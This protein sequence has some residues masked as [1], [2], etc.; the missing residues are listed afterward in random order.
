MLA[1]LSLRVSSAL[2]IHVQGWTRLFHPDGM[3]YFYH[4]EN[5]GDSLIETLMPTNHTLNHRGRIQMLI[6]QTLGY[7][8]GQ[9]TTLLNYELPTPAGPMTHH[10]IC[11]FGLASIIQM[12]RT[13]RDF[14]VHHQTRTILYASEQADN[15]FGNSS[16]S[17]DHLREFPVYGWNAA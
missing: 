16:R 1:M 4:E 10:P 9:W 17:M 8:C 13:S 12:G 6:S 3:R 7:T 14:F 11:T 5:V 15:F 2:P